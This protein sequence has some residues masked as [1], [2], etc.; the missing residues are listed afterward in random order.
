MS[1]MKT[2]REER[3]LTIYEL[4]QVKRISEDEYAVRSQSG[5]GTY[6]R[7]EGEIDMEKDSSAD[8]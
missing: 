2:T 5:N 7:P 3:G 1:D 4:G 8:F 6:S